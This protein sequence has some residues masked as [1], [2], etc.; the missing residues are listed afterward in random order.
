MAWPALS[1][2]GL[3]LAGPAVSPPR[4][5]LAWLALAGLAFYWPACPGWLGPLAALAR[6]AWPG[7]PLPMWLG[8]LSG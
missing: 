8:F 2:L 4:L 6:P 7:Q 3:A 1:P 5:A